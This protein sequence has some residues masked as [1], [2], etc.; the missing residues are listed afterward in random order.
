MEE[1][2]TTQ[3]VE[4]KKPRK[5]KTTP[6]VEVKEKKK[7]KKQ[8]ASDL[9]R[10]MGSIDVE[11]LNISDMRVSHANKMGVFYFQLEPNEAMIIS[12]EELY[13]VKTKAKKCFV[14]H[15]IIITEVLNEEY[16]IDDIMTFL[17]LDN[18]YKGIEDPNSDFL[19]A[20]VVE[21]SDDELEAIL[22]KKSK[23]EIKR[24][25]C[26]AMFLHHSDDHDFTLSRSKERVICEALNLE[27][28]IK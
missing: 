6:K 19:E 10:N 25:A 12:L 15:M 9:R 27:S 18:I 13:E 14:D 23:K 3:E 17:G 8:I 21:T 1:N 2:K 16:K 5:K 28:L 11:I 26:K 24:I 4:V 22:K 20:L 7:S